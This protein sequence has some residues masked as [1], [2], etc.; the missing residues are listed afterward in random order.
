MKNLDGLNSISGLLLGTG[1]GILG[2]CI[3]KLYMV[4][5]EKKNPKL[6][7]ENEVEFNKEM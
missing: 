6:V 5:F 3:A 7:K 1:A 2:G 4:D